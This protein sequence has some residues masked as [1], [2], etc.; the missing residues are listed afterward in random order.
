MDIVFE[1]ASFAYESFRRTKK[2]SPPEKELPDNAFAL[3]DLCFSITSTQSVAILGRSGSGKSTLLNLFTGLTK[4]THGV[5]CIDGENIHSGK[6]S[7]SL[8][9]QRL[10]VVFQFPESQLF[11]LSVYDDVAY[12]PRNLRLAETVVRQRVHEALNAVGLPPA[13]FSR[14]DPMHL[15]QG[16]KRRAAIAGI[17]AM[18]PEMLILDEPTAGLDADGRE[19]LIAALHGCRSRGVGV[20]LISHDTGLA[21]QFSRRALVLDAGRL[22]YDGDLSELFR[23]SSSALR[24]GLEVPR[25]IRLA[26]KLPDH[27]ISSDEM[28]RLLTDDAFLNHPDQADDNPS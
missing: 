4:P 9:R 20:L 18:Q 28:Q 16:E 27:G 26:Q 13:D 11:E 22:S 3:R 12:G 23:D 21:I 14:I 25:A 2:A 5:I 19:R 8:L 15:S 1:H 10:G 6:V 24:Y 17:L 7:L